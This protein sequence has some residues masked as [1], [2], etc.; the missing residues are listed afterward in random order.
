MASEELVGLRVAVYARFSS[1]E[2]RESSIE[3]QNRRCKEFVHAHGGQIRDE[4]TFADRAI[5]GAGIDR[6]AYERMM[7]LVTNKPRE[8][9]VIVIEDLSRLSRAA[10]DLFT[11]QRLFEFLDVRL[12]GI[13]D[14]IDTFAKH[15]T[16]TFGLKSLV[17]TIYLNDLRDKTLRGLE[18]RALAGFATGG[19]CFGYSLR[20]EFGAGG[21]AIGTKIE[22]SDEQ[23]KIVRRIFM[24]YLDGHSFAGIAKALNGDGVNPPRVHVQ[25][26]RVGWKDSTIR[27]MLHNESY[28][29][30]WRYKSRQWRKVPGT[31]RRIPMRRD[32][33]KEMIDERPHLRII[34]EDT[35]LAACE[36]LEQVHRFYTRT[37]DGKPKGRALP[38]RANPYLFSSLLCCG[39]CGGKMVISGGSKDA[40]YR[41]EGHAKRGTC[42]NDLSVRESVVRTGL[43]DELRHRLASDQGI[44]YARK[45]LAE[46]LGELTRERDGDMRERRQRLDKLTRQID[47]LVDFIA[48]GHGSGAVADKLKGLERE[49]DGERRQLAVLEKQVTDPVQLPAPEDLLP[50]VFDLARRLTADVTAG[51]EQ[52]RQIFRDG[53]ITLVPQP[54]GFYVARSEILPLVLLT[55]PPPEDVSGGRSDQE[56]RYTASSCAGAISPL[57]HAKSPIFLAIGAL[58]NR[59]RCLSALRGL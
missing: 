33:Q 1:E 25:N 39:V 4:L 58:R 44:S 13:A 12:I 3:D 49:A 56:S 24:L 47:K 48:D 23:A 55:Q 8:V 37:S 43:L 53:R 19:V 52:L 41:C 27:A 34:D 5:S 31:N 51:R 54:D 15:S 30:R 42:K 45:R 26:R 10:A 2:Q 32:H 28:I 46:K 35:W 57:D 7:R 14:G 38:A 6:P 21:K 9:D 50:I 36:R 11:A 17:S 16:L 22:I 20:K 18:G 40:Y 29:G 59:T